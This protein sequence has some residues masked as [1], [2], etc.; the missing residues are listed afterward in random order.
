L[1]P[2]G[3][4]V[5]SVPAEPRGAGEEN[6]DE[7]GRLFHPYGAAELELLFGRLGF[8]QTSW[9]RQ[10]DG[11]GRKGL[12][13]LTIHFWHD[14]RAQASVQQ[15][16]TVIRRDRKV[17]TYKLALLRALCDLAQT[18]PK[19][20]A[21]LPGDRVG[22]PLGLVVTRWLRYY[23][24]LVGDESF[25]PQMRGEKPGAG[26]ISFRSELADLIA[27]YR[28]CGGIEAFCDDL[29]RGV[30]DGQA[31]AF[32][33]AVKK[34]AVAI[35]TG[36]VAHTL[37][38]SGEG[39]IFTF[40]GART[41]RAG[42]PSTEQSLADSLGRIVLPAALWKE[43]SLL[44]HWIEESSI[45]RWAELTHEISEKRIAVSRVLDLL[46]R[47]PGVDRDT[48]L[49]RDL[50]AA[51]PALRCAW[52]DRP[53]S[54]AK[55]DVDHVIPF[56]AWK[57]NDLWNLLPADARVNRNK[58]DRIVTADLL[59]RRRDPI[60]ACWETLRAASADRFDAEARFALWPRDTGA[61]DWRLRTWAG[62]VEA[63]ETTAMRRNLERWEGI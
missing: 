8:V 19:A 33:A 55:F 20:A 5:I 15:V 58:L 62:L 57:N 1:K 38:T 53:L 42:L 26:G 13:W 63:V 45:L 30:P 50:Y 46:L 39:R 59:H 40:E 35:V 52:T 48:A 60:I 14:D 36:P 18:A 10:G 16:E 23:W 32:R 37:A 9:Q 49:A 3:S 51:L 11:C 31:A 6:R 29:R 2:Q 12:E 21:F 41:P 34:T 28:G 54:R 22:V 4:L 43:L 56:S 27:G 47:R 61:A 25:I 24:P 17:A 7:H 44:G